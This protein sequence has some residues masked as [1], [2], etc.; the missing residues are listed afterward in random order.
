MTEIPAIYRTAND[1][2]LPAMACLRAERSGTDDYWGNR[3]A[4]YLQGTVNPQQAL[5]SRVIYVAIKDDRVVGFIAGH[6]SRRFGCQG[7]L[8]WIDVSSEYRGTGIS[9]TLL[10]HLAA[11]FVDQ[12]A[13][14]VCVN[15]ASDN[16]VAQNFYR[17][18]GAEDLSDHWLIWKDISVVL[19]PG[20]TRNQSKST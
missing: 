17:R 4:G 15:C 14:I 20:C 1:S 11:W 10:R 12:A 18:L 9:G 13:L 8:Q 19:E 3:I 6:L 7:E 2:D 16:A 5:I